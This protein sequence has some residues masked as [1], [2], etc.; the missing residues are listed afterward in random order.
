MTELIQNTAQESAFYRHTACA[1]QNHNDKKRNITTNLS[2]SICQYVQGRVKGTLLPFFGSQTL[3]NYL[4]RCILL[5]CHTQHKMLLRF[6][7]DYKSKKSFCQQSF[8]SLPSF[9]TH[10]S[11]G[12]CVIFP[13]IPN[14]LPVSVQTIRFSG[15]SR[16]LK[17]I[18]P[19]E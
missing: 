3:P 1:A 9:F 13:F 10:T 11:Y 18:I 12:L 6:F 7:L 16:R 14:F 17:K 5:Y 8:T 2:Q 15:R 19:A 4:F